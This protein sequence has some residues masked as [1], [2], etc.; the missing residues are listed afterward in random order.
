MSGVKKVL[1]TNRATFWFMFCVACLGVQFPGAAAAEL[2]DRIVVIVN[3]KVITQSDIDQALRGREKSTQ[4][5]RVQQLIN[6][7]VLWEEIER[8]GIVVSDEEVEEAVKNVRVQNQYSEEQ[9]MNQLNQEGLTLTQYKKNLKRELQQEQFLSR[10]VY[11]RI[12][13]SDYDLQEYYRRHSGEFEGYEK[14]R[15]L[16]IFLTPESAPGRDIMELGSDIVSQLRKGASFTAMVKKYSKG[17]FAD[18]GGDSGLLETSMMNRELVQILST[19]KMNVIS[20]PKPTP[21]QGVFIFKVV[22]RRNPKQRAF[23]D[24][25]GMI[26][27]KFLQERVQDELERYLIEARSRHFIE[28]RE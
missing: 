23:E 3:D 20:D 5:D 8:Q 16:E 27:Q 17:A 6:D 24:V 10:L 25:K 13:V 22:E 14:I 1:W 7:K 28:I 2:V 15:F 18:R 4:A 9:L 12:R 21:N 19:L 26:Q 11:P